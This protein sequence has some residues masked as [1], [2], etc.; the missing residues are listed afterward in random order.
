MSLEYS[1]YVGPFMRV[2]NGFDYTKFEEIVCP[3]RGE[4][5]NDDEHGTL[6]LNQGLPDSDREMWFA[7][8]Y[9]QGIQE[10]DAEIISR[11][12]ASFAT[13]TKPMRAAAARAG[14]DV[15]IGW[16]VVPCIS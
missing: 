3:G 4:L 12:T 8:Q 13:I 7:N 1:V 11:E 9:E 16:G 5:G 2:P 10:I 15:V 14:D 6:V